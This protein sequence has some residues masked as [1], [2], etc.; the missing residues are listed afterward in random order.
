MQVRGNSEGDLF[1]H[2]DGS[3]LMRY[4]FWAVTSR[5]LQE[6]GIVGWKSGTHSFRKGAAS[7]AA[8]LGYSKEQIKKVG[9][10]SSHRFKS[11]VLSLPH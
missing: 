5:G 4:Q 10:W 11:Y 9:R 8:A 1:H 7:T 3:P 2:E 6:A